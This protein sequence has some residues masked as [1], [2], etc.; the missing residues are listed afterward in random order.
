[1][2]IIKIS[3]FL[4]FLTFCYT[5][6]FSLEPVIVDSNIK[7]KDTGPI[8]KNIEFVYDEKETL[9]LKDIETEKNWKISDNDIISFKA[10]EG[11][12]WFRFCLINNQ[13][14]G[15]EVYLK[16]NYALND[17]IDLYIKNND[18][19]YIVKKNGDRIPF[20]K[21]DIQYRIPVLPIY[22]NAYQKEVYYLRI[23]SQ[24]N[25]KLSI[26]LTIN[27]N[28]TKNAII[29][30][31]I[32]WFLY[33]I[34]ISMLLYHIFL[35]F[36]I[37]DYS[38]IYFALA[39]LSFLLLKM[40]RSGMA[41]QYLWPNSPNWGNICLPLF[42][43]IGLATGCM[44]FYSYMNTK[45]ISPIIYWPIKL[46]ACVNAF[47]VC[48]GLFINYNINIMIASL[49]CILCCIIFFLSIIIS[50]N[51]I[52]K[53]GYFILISFCIFFVAST[54]FVLQEFDYFLISTSLR[55]Y[56]DY[57]PNFA[58]ASAMILLAI[59]LAGKINVMKIEKE[60]AQELAIK[61]LHK[62]D[63]LKDEFL[64]NTSHELKTPLSSIIGIA[65]GIFSSVSKDNVKY[66]LSLIISSG[67]RLLNLV[68]DIL[69]FQR[70]KHKDI[71]L[72]FNKVDLKSTVNII[73]ELLNPFLR[74]KEVSLINSISTIDQ[75]FLYV[76]ENRLQQILYNLVSNAIKFTDKGEISISASHADANAFIRIS[77]SDTGIGI[78]DNKLDKIFQYFEQA[79]KNIAVEYGG[80]GIGLTVTKHLV[81]LHGGR[82]WVESKI[83]KGSQF[84]FTLPAFLE[85]SNDLSTVINEQ[86][87]QENFPDY[88]KKRIG[89]LIGSIGCVP[90][91]AS[92]TS[93]DRGAQAGCG[94]ESARSRSAPATS[95]VSGSGTPKAA[96]VQVHTRCSNRSSPS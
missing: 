63:R 22:L 5:M 80:T 71:E 45:D 59:G 84:I 76:D 72:K 83:G 33:G 73:I 92:R 49:S 2:K 44:F 61:N 11:A 40:V 28:F 56:F 94:R 9:N 75:F 60:N 53:P 82:I 4:F 7:N 69:D 23:K 13:N 91:R 93:S 85:G 36:S 24:G 20:N 32:L 95:V 46:L 66:N 30:D 18:G 88:N 50:I 35:Y 17:F 29:E 79:D 54:L 57:V 26:T 31:G 68:N 74:G 43:Y 27:A 10:K 8:D 55:V 16:I 52:T 89:N 48:L 41:F 62:A 58:S 6:A 90:R 77:V 19:R 12:Y 21:R 67:R 70:L 3:L 87:L 14:M 65:E 37:R 47:L 34:F 78:P 39:I 81:E 1:M 86:I 64:T 96:S 38:Y 25:I 42:L 51:K 15:Q